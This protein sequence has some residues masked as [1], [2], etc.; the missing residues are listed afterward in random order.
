MLLSYVVRTILV[1]PSVIFGPKPFK[2]FGFWAENDRFLSWVEE[3]W[4]IR[5][6]GA[7]MFRLYKKFE[8]NVKNFLKTKNE[9]VYGRIKQRV[10][11]TKAW[12]DRAPM[13]VLNYF[14]KVA[15]V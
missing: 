11:Q 8:S 3:H 5:V 6:L 2:F 12:L 1:L 7:P 9:E 13:E 4:S 14:G 15:C 10:M